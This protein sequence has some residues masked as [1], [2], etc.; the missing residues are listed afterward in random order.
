MM[1]PRSLDL[2][3]IERALHTYTH[4]DDATGVRSWLI[5]EGA[6]TVSAAFHPAA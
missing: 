5:N 3:L 6:S 1:I 2:T 4:I